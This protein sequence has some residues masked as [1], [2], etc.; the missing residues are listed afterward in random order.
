M[1]FLVIF[2][3]SG[4]VVY[5]ILHLQVFEGEKWNK[6]A[7]EISLK[8]MSIKAPRGNI[9][10]DNGSLLATSVPFY[11][12]AFDPTV[13]AD[14]LFNREID[15]L[16]WHLSNFFQ[17]YSTSRYLRKIKNARVANDR[18]MILSHRRIGYQDKKKMEE[19]PLFRKGRMRGGVIFE[20]VE[21][22]ILPFS[23]LGSR[24]IGYINDENYGAGLEY[25]FNHHLAGRDGEALF[26]KIAGGRWKP[27]YHDSEVR[28]VGG[29]DIETTIDVNIQDVAESALLKS[30]I[31]HNAT[32]GCVMVMEV[33]TGEIKA[34]SNLSKDR[35]GRYREIYNYAVASQGVREPG[36]TFKLLSMLALLEEV[37]LSL[38][39]TIDTGNGQHKFHNTVMRD[40]KPG[41]YGEL[42]VKEV[43]EKSS[44]IGVAKLVV[45]HFGAD[46]RR[47]TDYIQDLGLDQPLG[48][49]MIGEGRPYVKDPSDSSWSGISLPWMS[50]GYEL[51]M[52]PIHTLTFFNAIANDGKMIRPI[53]VREV[54]RADWILEK[55]E[56]T[57]LKDKVCS[58]ATLKKLRSM[59]EGVV[60]NG[61][62]SNIRNSYYKIAGKTGTAQKIRN[63]RYINRYYTSFAG[64][65]P[66]ET[67][68]YSCIVVI[69]EPKGY[70][71]YGADV[72]APVF[73]EIADK[74]YV[75]DIE[76][77]S[78]FS[79]GLQKKA[80][81]FPVIRA[82]YKD[83]LKIICDALNIGNIEK[84]D[85]AWVKTGI[86]ADSIVWK[87]HD[88]H[89]SL[90]PDVRGMT[91]RD[92]L[93]LLENAG[94]EV[95]YHGTGRVEQQSQLP[96][97]KALKGSKINLNLS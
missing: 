26:Q 76:M 47:F 4:V 18:Y 54:R 7:E 49:Q 11:R 51:K 95:S 41:G 3:I 10:S 74:L 12:V 39:D 93:Y 40:H 32:Y 24:T 94:L 9:Y 2:L 27:I 14:E 45:E 8:F 62:A 68:R 6:L 90:V 59:M 37:K 97:K 79:A 86:K 65:F 77:H 1:S 44:N 63:G 20:K 35:R 89:W 64:Y 73:K 72:A 78:D 30:L 36:S 42:T 56:T 96:G 66:A 61:T 43:F 92:A 33:E 16:A 31:E 91:L 85:A 22:R 52:A 34:I 19:W 21:K 58:D 70:R 55:Y 75:M 82:G 67:P 57:V 84:E 60:A 81:I 29:L 80:G 50:H 83:D 23:Y 48:F 5:R 25:S 28:P 88:M 53:I 17:D 15:S 71:Q 13:S 87:S 69:D 38:G 46:P